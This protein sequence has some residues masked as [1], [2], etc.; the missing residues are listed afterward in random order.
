MLNRRYGGWVADRS[1]FGEVAREAEHHP[2]RIALIARR[3]EEEVA[4]SYAELVDGAWRDAVK[5]AELGVLPGAR[6]GLL[7]ENRPDWLRSYLALSAAD[8]QTIALADDLDGDDVRAALGGAPPVAVIG[9]TLALERLPRELRDEL[10]GAGVR[11][12]DFERGL[13]AL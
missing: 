7:C 1:V 10:R 12:L 9:S 6:V 13:A 8:A 5:L 11:L 2:A 3:G 4:V